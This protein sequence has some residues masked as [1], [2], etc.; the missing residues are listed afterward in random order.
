MCTSRR[1]KEPSGMR[2]SKSKWGNFLRMSWN[3]CSYQFSSSKLKCV[4]LE[5]TR[6]VRIRRKLEF[7]YLLCHFLFDY[8]DGR[9]WFLWKWGKNLLNVNDSTNLQELVLF[10]YGR[11]NFSVRY[12]NV[13]F[14]FT[15]DLVI[16]FWKRFYGWF[17]CIRFWYN[18]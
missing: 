14:T 7:S 5:V 3:I 11:K 10:L 4:G 1:G 13:H 8:G 16:C 9:K 18:L 15:A 12:V 6:S 17:T 2:H